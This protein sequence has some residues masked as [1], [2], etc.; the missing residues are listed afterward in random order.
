MAPYLIAAFAVG[1]VVGMALGIRSAS[2]A[3]Q[4]GLRRAGQWQNDGA[5][6]AGEREKRWCGTRSSGLAVVPFDG[7]AHKN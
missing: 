2:W 1:M 5:D 3:V 6:R 7:T 4:K